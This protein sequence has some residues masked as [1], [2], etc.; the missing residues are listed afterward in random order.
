MQSTTE[1]TDEELYIDSQGPVIGIIESVSPQGS[2]LNFP[3]E[4]FLNILQQAV[5]VQRCDAGA[6]WVQS[7]YEL[8]FVIALAQDIQEGLE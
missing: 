3:D 4:L 2:D 5:F 7:F 1:T 6:E 8:H